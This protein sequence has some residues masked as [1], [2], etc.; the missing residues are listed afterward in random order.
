MSNLTDTAKDLQTMKQVVTD[1]L[2]ILGWITVPG[3]ALV[4][5]YFHTA[6][7]AKVAFVYLADFG[8]NSCDYMLQGDY[9][10]EGR[11]CL[12]PHAV[13]IPKNSDLPTIHGLVDSFAGNAEKVISETFAAR[14]VR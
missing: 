3:A 9:Q 1:H 7:G 2:L 8:A 12:E 6:V 11:N 4:E 5:K 14:L 10:S 13:L